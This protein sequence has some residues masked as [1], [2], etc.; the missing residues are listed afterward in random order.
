MIKAPQFWFKNPPQLWSFLLYP[1]SFLYQKIYEIRFRK[2]V[3]YSSDIPV[4]CVGNI[5]VGGTGKTPICLELAQWLQ[6]KGKTVVFVSRGY[7]GSLQGPIQVDPQNHTYQQVG[8]EPLLLAQVA[9]TV[10]AKNRPKGIKMA[11]EMGADII[12]MDDGLQNPS[13]YK[14]KSLLVL[15][16]KVG[17][18]NGMTIP[19]GPL[20]EPLKNALKRVHGVIIMGNDD[21]HLTE[22]IKKVSPHMVV[23]N[24]DL[25]SVNQ[26]IKKE[27][28]VI[29][30]AG[31]GNPSKFFESVQTQGYNCVKMVGYA[32]HYPYRLKDV[33][34]LKKMALSHHA[35]L[36]TT[37][38]DSVRL[39]IEFRKSVNVLDVKIKW[40]LDNAPYIL[41][42]DVL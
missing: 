24:G 35:E 21:C 25:E 31:I 22:N 26:K 42:R 18:G 27:R 7:G 5:S 29:A 41:L 16:G 17:L 15:D 10:I 38:K 34:K 1:L 8:D 12:L 11:I 14:N 13:V 9:Q 20:R 30:F 2:G 36:I 23:V 37:T 6:D 3:P 19:S 33:E 28:R 4:V 39:P 40:R 32:D